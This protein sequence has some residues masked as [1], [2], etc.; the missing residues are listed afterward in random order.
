MFFTGSVFALGVFT[1]P[2]EENAAIP[3]SLDGVWPAA[4]GIMHLLSAP[5]MM[6]TGIYL[7]S[8]VTHVSTTN[9]AF[10]QSKTDRLRILHVISS[11]CYSAF[12]L[13][14]AATAL[15]SPILIRIAIALQSVPLGINYLLNTEVLVA[16]F[17]H[18]PGFIV[19]CAL[20]T[21]G[22]GTILQSWAFNTVIEAMGCAKALYATA[23]GLTVPSLLVS[24]F[25]SWPSNEHSQQTQAPPESEPLLS[26]GGGDGS[27][28]L[29]WSRL[30]SLGSFW[31]Y[32]IIVF[33]G[34]APYAL[35]SFFFKLG[36]VFGKSST[37]MVS[38]F[39]VVAVLCTLLGLMAGWATDVM[40]FGNGYF[41]S[42]A[43]NLAILTMAVQV[44]LFLAMIP[45]SNNGN[46]WGFVLVAGTL[47]V[48]TASHYGCAAIM[49]RELFGTANSCMVFGIGAGLSVGS[50]EGLSAEM[51]STIEALTGR[52]ALV[53]TSYNLY[54]WIGALWST[55]G[56]ICALRVEMCDV[57]AGWKGDVRIEV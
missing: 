32:V 7:D 51:M 19:G 55:L 3:H 28:K 50:G 10:G 44:V 25:I 35:I 56:L 26:G 41:R 46:F 18:I 48:I 12:A 15:S 11:L 14:A 45:L 33:T 36:H 17:P 2:V 31:L 37:L 13:A 43:K 6:L 49:A 40:R 53:P 21:Y 20:L 38:I 27:I 30:R 1:V 23:L 24:A 42:G 4:M 29:P 9:L 39:Q 57:S 34:G 5:I 54:Y 47:V 52:E 16:W 22:A 8:A